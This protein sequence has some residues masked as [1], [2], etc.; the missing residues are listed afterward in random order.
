MSTLRKL[1]FLII[2]LLVHAGVV[3]AETSEILPKWE[4]GGGFGYLR[5][6]HYPGSNQ[7]T[8]LALPFPTFIYRGE[9]LRADDREGAKIL[10]LKSPAWS[11]QLGG[12]L[13]PPLASSADSAREGMGD[14]PVVV[15]LGP[16]LQRTIDERW[17]AKV[18]LYQA[19]VTG[20]T[21]MRGSGAIWEGST[22]YQTTYGLEFGLFDEATT[23]FSLGIMGA[24]QK[25]HELYY[26]VPSHHATPTRS[27]YQADAGLLATQAS[28]FQVVKRGDL[29][30]YLGV[31]VSDYSF[32]PNRASPLL[33]TRQNVSLLFGMTYSFFKS[34]A[35][36]AH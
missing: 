27:A 20:F 28:F 4:V 7:Y 36:E 17:S 8:D 3:H 15:A 26:S 23:T 10:I 12:V 16:Q 30:V 13:F 32:S 24:T 2:T 33:E 11:L 31:R 25:L 5:F 34:S 22:T 18:G 1:L 21:F 14:L 6:E 29:A 9:V 35:S 19:L